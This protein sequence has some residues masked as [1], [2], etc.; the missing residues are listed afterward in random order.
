MSVEQGL[1]RCDV[2]VSATRVHAIRHSSVGSQL[3]LPRAQ[4]PFQTVRSRCETHHGQW[5]MYVI[6]TPETAGQDGGDNS[7]REGL[8]IRCRRTPSAAGRAPVVFGISPRPNRAG[9]RRLP[10]GRIRRAGKDCRRG[11]LEVSSHVLLVLV[12]IVF[13]ASRLLGSPH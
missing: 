3:V 1:E 11:T 8:F 12:L 5:T 2:P 6:W 13:S 9:R 4:R 7:A 10:R